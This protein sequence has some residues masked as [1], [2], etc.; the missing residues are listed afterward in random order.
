[1]RKKKKRSM[2]VINTTALPDIIFM[3]LFFFMVVTVIRE[4]PSASKMQLPAL[5][6]IDYVKKHEHFIN[7]S[8][9]VNDSDESYFINNKLIAGLKQVEATL[10]KSKLDSESP[11]DLKV[12]LI[13]DQ[14][15]KMASVNQLKKILQKL[16]LYKV[17][18]I[19]VKNKLI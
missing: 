8:L 9:M 12:K 18:Y 7:L 3:L 13:V 4:N 16:E 14:S 2:P 10:A 6:H 17:E 11:H 5:K 1:M 15:A 19:A